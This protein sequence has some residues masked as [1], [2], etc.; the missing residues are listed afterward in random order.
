MFERKS[1]LKVN[2][3]IS[4]SSVVIFL[5]LAC[6]IRPLEEFLGVL[7]RKNVLAFLYFLPNYVNSSDGEAWS[8]I[9]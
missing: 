8:G 9:S 4:T 5:L 6:K 1:D 3:L 7:E 2:N